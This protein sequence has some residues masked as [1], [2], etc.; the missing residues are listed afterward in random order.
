MAG[1]LAGNPQSV[2][3]Q[4]TLG[5]MS[6]GQ[7]FQIAPNSGTYMCGAE[8]CT[9][10]GAPAE[11]YKLMYSG[12]SDG[13]TR[14]FIMVDNYCA[15]R[16]ADCTHAY[17]TTNNKL[18]YGTSFNSNY[19][20]P[21]QSN[22]L[23]GDRQSQ[24]ILIQLENF[25]N[26]LPATIGGV[27]KATAIPSRTFNMIGIPWVSGTGAISSG[28]CQTS[29]NS[30]PYGNIQAT[31]TGTVG[32][33]GTCTMTSRVSLPSYEE[34]LGGLYGF[35]YYPPSGTLGYAFCQARYGAAGCDQIGSTVDGLATTATNKF[36]QSG[37]L[38]RPYHPWLRSPA[39]GYV[40]DVFRVR[41]DNAGY[42]L[43]SENA[44]F[45]RGVL[46][47][48]Y[49]QSSIPIL[50]GAGT[51]AS[52]YELGIPN[53]TPT[54]TITN[55]AGNPWRSAVSGYTDITVS[56]SVTDPDTQTQAIQY[57]IDGGAWTA[58]QNLVAGTGTRS[59]SFSVNVSGL[60]EGNHTVMTRTYDGV[61]YSAQTGTLSF[62]LDKTVPTATNVTCNSVSCTNTTSYYSA[63]GFTIAYTATDSGSGIC[64]YQ[65]WLY[66]PI[67]PSP[68]TTS[69]ASNS[70]A[71]SA[72][73][74]G[75]YTIHGV[76]YDCVGNYINI[77]G[78]FPTYVVLDT[79]APTFTLSPSPTGTSSWTTS[80]S[81][82][83]S[84][85]D[86]GGS[87]LAETRYSTTNN[88]NSACTSG[89]TVGT[90]I[91]LSAGTNNIYVCVR[92][93]AGNVSTSAAAYNTANVY[94]INKDPEIMPPSGTLSNLTQGQIIQIAPNSGTF[95]CGA[96]TCTS[97][98]ATAEPYKLMY[99]GLSDATTRGFIMIDNYCAWRSADC[100]YAYDTNNEK[101]WSGTSWNSNAGNTT[102]NNDLGGGR[103][104]QHILMQLENFYNSLPATIGG[105][106]KA[107]AIPSRTFNMIGI[108]W[109]SGTGAIS[110]GNCQTSTNTTPYGNI[111]ATFTGTIGS[112]GTCTMTSRVSLPSVEE[113]LG[114][115]YG[116]GYYPPSGTL[117]YA[118]CLARYGAAG[119]NQTG[120]TVDGLA[121]TATN[122][123]N[124]TAYLKRPY[125]PWL[126]SLTSGYATSVFNVNASTATNSLG[127]NYSDVSRGVLPWLYLQSSIPIYSGQGTYTDP[128]ALEP[129][130]P[131]VANSADPS[132]GAFAS[133][134]SGYSS[135]TLAGTVNDL[136]VGQTLTI[137][138]QI[139]STAG[140]WSNLTTLTANGSNQP[141]SGTVNLPSG[142]TAG[143]HTIY[144][145]VYDG[146]SYSANKS[147]SFILDLSAPTNT[148]S[149][150]GGVLC[151][152][153]TT[154]YCTAPTGINLSTSSDGSG[155]GIGAYRTQ[156]DTVFAA[157]DVSPSW[158]T[159]TPPSNLTTTGHTIAAA[160][161]TLYYQTRDTVGNVSAVESISYYVNSTPEV[162]INDANHNQ[163]IT[164]YTPLVLSGTFTDLDSSQSVTIKATINGIDYV[165]QTYPTTSSVVAWEIVIPASSLLGLSPSQLTNFPLTITD[166]AGVSSIAYYTGQISV[167]SSTSSEIYLSV[168][169]NIPFALTI[170]K[171]GAINVTFGTNQGI[172]V[173]TNSSDEIIVSG[174]LASPVS[175][176]FGVTD[177]VFTVLEEPSF[178]VQNIEFV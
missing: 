5:G 150:V 27:A 48:L 71:Y 23:G 131:T 79:V 123:F 66:G 104:S 177:L 41:A 10:N 144:I 35:G 141:W 89:G 164:P 18:W 116:Y 37:Y 63:T 108:P 132:I 126:R 134:V 4:T 15:W 8:I 115:L 59:Y 33:T 119:C 72:L 162:E 113:W 147:V 31:F 149:L 110:S 120:S 22:N 84:P 73:P 83:I 155:A 176:P 135:L 34:W 49:F 57:S 95:M 178:E 85:A 76:I 102:Y 19:G 165:S 46:P 156:W 32:T 118:F 173:S 7:I 142:L 47:W 81:L 91:T 3:A 21:T 87:G 69:Q 170:G 14:G 151:T 143:S 99:S 117:G 166:S 78:P 127:Y 16:S 92:D 62:R 51:Y 17:N 100:T 159:G 36:N 1:V 158:V 39:S 38:K 163:V 61:A 112:S 174:S 129:S 75:S 30:T 121:T 128:Y 109:T 124:Q 67:T 152:G 107:T 11:P 175:I 106:A 29:T 103:Q 88:L 65:H 125:Y 53:T 105:V 167:S 153:I 101:R 145:R 52:P 154:I 138:Y 146:Y 161:H 172:T 54:I 6:I 77:A 96:S 168:I 26:S 140:S 122:K 60:T 56:G 137:Q 24:H 130:D 136:D 45:D 42:S 98:G 40:T 12:L 28:N 139:D 97:N 93:N 13:A 70:I 133:Y 114:G 44:N 9:T 86:T 2:S 58:G 55:P 94:Q 68:R 25:Y 50:S 64:T 111:G 171:V 82:T 90:S 160:T 20:N 74:N 169:K 80:T 157:G 148:V 43:F